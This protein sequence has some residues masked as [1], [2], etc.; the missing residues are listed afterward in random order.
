MFLVSIDAT[1][2]QVFVSTAGRAKAFISCSVKQDFFF[3]CVLRGN[4]KVWSC[5]FSSSI[6]LL[7]LAICALRHGF[8][9][10]TG[11]KCSALFLVFDIVSLSFAFFIPAFFWFLDYW[12]VFLVRYQIFVFLSLTNSTL[13]SLSVKLNYKI[14]DA[15]LCYRC[16]CMVDIFSIW[17]WKFNNMPWNIF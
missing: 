4:R 10:R 14:G 16:Y 6:L 15:L 17:T 7:L 5:A 13:I 2:P 9:L 12:T 11:L 8:V 1:H 3:S